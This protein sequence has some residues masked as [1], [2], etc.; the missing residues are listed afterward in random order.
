MAERGRPFGTFKFDNLQ[1]LQDGIDKYFTE[2]DT[3]EKP[4]TLEGL[5]LA[6]NITPQTLCNYGSKDYADGIY[7]EAINRAR[8]RCVNYASE[9]L[10]DKNGSNGA[11]FYLSNNGERMGGLKYSDKQEFSVAASDDLDTETLNSRITELLSR[12]TPEEKA[13][14]KSDPD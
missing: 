1:D 11:K 12:L 7:F 9:R 5:S 3:K 6:L 10:F 13:A 14:L 2:Q 4:Y 8:L